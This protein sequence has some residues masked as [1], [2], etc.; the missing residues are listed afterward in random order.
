M[1]DLLLT[2]VAPADVGNRNI[3][4]FTQYP[5]RAPFS[6]GTGG[7]NLLCGVCSFVL[8]AGA[9]SAAAIAPNLLIRCP[10][11]GSFNGPPAEIDAVPDERSA[12]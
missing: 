7:I 12:G 8:V 4:A 9:D 5:D 10:S 1:P 6:T 2:S 3:L 11:C